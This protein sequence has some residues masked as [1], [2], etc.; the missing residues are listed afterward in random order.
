MIAELDNRVNKIIEDQEWDKETF[1][2][3]T[4]SDD[5]IRKP[6]HVG[7]P[8]DLLLLSHE[9]SEKQISKSEDM[10]RTAL[11]HKNSWEQFNTNRKL[12]K[13]A[14]I[15]N[16][17]SIAAGI[18]EFEA[19]TQEINRG[20]HNTRNGDPD[21]SNPLFQVGTYDATLFL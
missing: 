8:A 19:G 2:I 6:T 14:Q 18:K 11:T 10:E 17:D 7:L 20:L 5:E 16:I 4:P 12:M 3:V 1:D 21:A 15:R 13:N 9:E